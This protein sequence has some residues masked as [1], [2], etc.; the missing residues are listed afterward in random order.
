M[1]TCSIWREEHICS[2]LCI[3]NGGGIVRTLSTFIPLM[4]RRRCLA[5]LWMSSYT[6]CLIWWQVVS[7]CT[8]QGSHLCHYIRMWD[9]DS[10]VGRRHPTPMLAD[11][12][13]CSGGR[14][15]ALQLYVT[16]CWWEFWYRRFQWDW[17]MRSYLLMVGYC[18][19]LGN[20]FYASW[21]PMYR[22]IDRRLRSWLACIVVLAGYSRLDEN[23]FGLRTFGSLLTFW[24]LGDLYFKQL[25]IVSTTLRKVELET[26]REWCQDFQKWTKLYCHLG[27]VELTWAHVVLFLLLRRSCV[28]FRVNL[29]LVWRLERK[30]GDCRA[31]RSWG[32]KHVS[33]D[34][35]VGVTSV[36]DFIDCGSC[37]LLW[38]EHV[39]FYRIYMSI[40]G[41]KFLERNAGFDRLSVVFSFYLCGL[42]V[43][44]WLFLLWT[45]IM[46]GTNGHIW[47][48]ASVLYGQG[49]RSGKSHQV[50]KKRSAVETAEELSIA[51][52]IGGALEL[53]LMFH[54]LK[55]VCTPMVHYWYFL[56]SIELSLANKPKNVILSTAHIHVPWHLSHLYERCFACNMQGYRSGESHHQVI[57]RENDKREMRRKRS[58]WCMFRNY[59]ET[60]NQ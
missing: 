17:T 5:S 27:H 11:I 33:L 8:G 44:F 14:T 32:L 22:R 55:Y 42:V 7:P 19:E 38:R 34:T 26:S 53:S 56:F 28:V 29:T 46:W 50:M 57:G 40:V 15:K 9:P 24:S 3:V 13:F 45:T 35:W 18:K 12:R 48:N 41:C 2:L 16:G 20:L 52:N 36:S 43:G 37:V 23:Q 47:L 4:L 49:H 30:E 58:N 1:R 51:D 60:S 59:V 31:L 10:S 54:I 39:L 6:V 21:G 25:G